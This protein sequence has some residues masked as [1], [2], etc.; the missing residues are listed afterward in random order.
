MYANF[1]NSNLKKT[2][3]E[4][5]NLSNS[6]MSETKLKNIILNENNLRQAQ[7]FKTNLNKIDFRTCDI[8]GITVDIGDL[9]GMIVNE[10]QAINLAKLLGIV[11]K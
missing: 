9:K 2:K 5:T 4:G 7:L 3:I 11:I 10:F 8:E 6:N 1:S